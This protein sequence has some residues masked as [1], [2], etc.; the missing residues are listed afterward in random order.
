MMDPRVPRRGDG[1][2]SPRIVS[3]HEQQLL[4]ATLTS[5]PVIDRV[6]GDRSG[7][8]PEV[9]RRRGGNAGE[10]LEAPV[11][12]GAETTRR[13]AYRERVGGHGFGPEVDGVDGLLFRTDAPAAR[14]IVERLNAGAALIGW[15]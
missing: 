3:V 15:P 6:R 13:V 12:E 1:V 10:L 5:Q 8:R 11:R 4:L 14:R 7:Q 2:N 9:F